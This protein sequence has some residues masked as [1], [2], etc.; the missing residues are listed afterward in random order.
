MKKI[1]EGR[2]HVIDPPN[3]KRVAYLVEASDVGKTQGRY[4]GQEP[5]VFQSDDVGRLVEVTTG[6]SPGYMS[7]R[8]SSMFEDLRK[9]YPDPKPYRVT[10]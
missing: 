8:F 9:Q 2:Q 4:L 5:Y 6:F 3:V 10:E 1:N 7:W